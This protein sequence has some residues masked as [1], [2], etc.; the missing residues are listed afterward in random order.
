MLIFSLLFT[1]VAA[2]E[3]VCSLWCRW[4]SRLV[5]SVAVVTV[6][7]PADSVTVDPVKIQLSHNENRKKQLFL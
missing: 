4:N 3:G 1:V 6:S 5:F 7:S 2:Q